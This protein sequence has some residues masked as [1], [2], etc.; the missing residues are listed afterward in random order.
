MKRIIYLLY[1]PLVLGS[2]T[3]GQQNKATNE[4]TDSLSLFEEQYS[5]TN[6]PFEKFVLLDKIAKAKAQTLTSDEFGDYF[7]GFKTQLD[8]LIA[9]INSNEKDFLYEHYSL[10]HDDNGNQITPP[11]WVQEKEKRYA[12]AGLYPTHIGEGI[13]E[14]RIAL[15]YFE[16][17]NNFLPQDIKDYLKIKEKEGKILSDGGLWV[18]FSELADEI[19]RYESF[20]ANHP[21]SK[22]LNEVNEKYLFY[23]N[24]YLNGIDNSPVKNK[25]GRL[26]PEA[27]AELQRFVK[28]HPDSP[29]AELAK[30]T[31][32]DKTVVDMFLL[33]PDEAFDGVYPPALRQ[34]MIKQPDKT[35]VIREGEET[36][37]CGCAFILQE[38]NVIWAN[39]DSSFPQ[40]QVYLWQLYGNKRLVAIYDRYYRSN[41]IKAYWYENGKLE[42]DD[43]LFAFVNDSINYTTDAF[44]D[45]E[46]VSEEVA[47]DAN[48]NYP[49]PFLECKFDVSP[50]GVKSIKVYYDCPYEYTNYEIL[51]PL[52]YYLQFERVGD[53]WTKARIKE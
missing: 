18:E 20:I 3:G 15:D 52:K 49:T 29:T 31:L 21:Q 33:L 24:I 26:L 27:K 45:L 44:F 39:C 13:E 16:N 50:N 10:H 34:K 40:F 30:M 14:F 11:D 4:T 28:A 46:N 42:K 2:C 17:F 36:Y 7:L 23:Q 8:S 43:N 35:H 53:K 9:E 19:I 41:E 5:Q 1:I 47:K 6:D 37:Y 22:L 48:I 32:E 51:E 25:K 38:E 12:D